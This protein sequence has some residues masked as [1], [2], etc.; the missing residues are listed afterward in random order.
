MFAP[1]LSKYSWCLDVPKE[2]SAR[3]HAVAV[4]EILVRANLCTGIHLSVGVDAE[5]ELHMN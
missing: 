2:L 5:I 3:I 4:Y 1:R